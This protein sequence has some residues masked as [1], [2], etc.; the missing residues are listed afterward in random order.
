MLPD[1]IVIIK[2]DSHVPRNQWRHGRVI[3]VIKSEDNLVRGAIIE[4]Y[5]NGKK[6]EIQR[7]VQKLIPLEIASSSKTPE[8]NKKLQ[9]TNNGQILPNVNEEKVL[10][11]VNVERNATRLTRTAAADAN[12]KIK[13]L[14]EDFDDIDP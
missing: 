4:V 13:L 11:N 7:P 10:P 8:S 5:L 6:H 12:A 1:D 3:S 9:S 14:N 2:D